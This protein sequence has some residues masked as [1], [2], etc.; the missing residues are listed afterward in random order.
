MFNYMVENLEKLIKVLKEEGVTIVGKIEEYKYCN[1]GRV[2]DNNG[3][4][5]ELWES[6]DSAFL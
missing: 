2:L 4:K 6:I 5:V 1:F 3:N